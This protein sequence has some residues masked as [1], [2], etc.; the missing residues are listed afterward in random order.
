[1]FFLPRSLYLTY[2]FMEKNQSDIQS[3]LNMV[4]SVHSNGPFGK[5][6]SVWMRMPSW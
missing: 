3:C 1:M 5:L 4:C 6:F 2:S